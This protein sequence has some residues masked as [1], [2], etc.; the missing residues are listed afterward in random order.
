[1][2]PGL[3][4]DALEDFATTGRVALTFGNLRSK[5]LPDGASRDLIKIAEK[6]WT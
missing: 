6:R 5:A 2:C 4:G 1:M 3:C